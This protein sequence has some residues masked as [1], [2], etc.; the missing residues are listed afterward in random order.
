MQG[1][2]VAGVSCSPVRTQPLGCNGFAGWVPLSEVGWEQLRIGCFVP[3]SHVG[4]GG[5]LLGSF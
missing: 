4:E 5:H 1:L 2:F 3:Q